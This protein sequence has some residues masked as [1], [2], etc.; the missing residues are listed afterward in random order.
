LLK[1]NK[2]KKNEDWRFSLKFELKEWGWITG[3]RVRIMK[4]EIELG[5]KTGDIVKDFVVQYMVIY[6][7]PKP[8]WLILELSAISM[9]SLPARDNLTYC[10][11]RYLQ[12]CLFLLWHI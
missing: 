5:Y 6:K 3:Q 8:K 4:V 10:Y 7:A 11:T 1:S 9:M 12:I 2:L